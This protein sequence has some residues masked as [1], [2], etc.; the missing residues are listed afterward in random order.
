MLGAFPHFENSLTSVN[1]PSRRSLVAKHGTADVEGMTMNKF[2]L[3]F[4]VILAFGSAQAVTDDAE[5]AIDYSKEAENANYE[6]EREQYLIRQGSTR[7]EKFSVHESAQAKT[8]PSVIVDSGSAAQKTYS[9]RS[10]NGAGTITY[11]GS[12]TRSAR[13]VGQ[14]MSAAEQAEAR[15]AAE[16]RYREAL[17]SG[18]IAPQED[19]AGDEYKSELEALLKSL[20]QNA[21]KQP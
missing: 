16:T 18:D 3:V 7:S 14:G 20:E 19:L 15:S 10:Q 5:K 1:I 13:T 4:A 9:V 21:A 2:A 8:Q 11:G 17:R 6:R 12:F